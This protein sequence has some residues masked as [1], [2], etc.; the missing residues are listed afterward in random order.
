MNSQDL[1]VKKETGIQSKAKE[2]GIIGKRSHK[3]SD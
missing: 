2:K 1:Q 3:P